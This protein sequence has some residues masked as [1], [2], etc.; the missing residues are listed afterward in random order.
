MPTTAETLTHPDFVPQRRVL[1]AR[2]ALLGRGCRSAGFAGVLGVLITALGLALF[3]SPGFTLGWCA[4]ML[5]LT[6]SNFWFQKRMEAPALSP[7]QADTLEW[8]HALRSAFSGVG[9]GSIATAIHPDGEQSLQVLF[10][11]LVMAIATANVA[12]LAASRKSFLAFLFPALG[13][14]ATHFII[15]PLAALPLTGWGIVLFMLILLAQHDSLH[16]TLLDTLQRQMESDATAQEQQVI[17]DTSA[18]AILFVK[19]DYIL[20]CNRR[21]AEL[22]QVSEWEAAGSPMWIWHADVAT[23]KRHAEAAQAASKENKPY[24]YEAQLRRRNG[25]TFWAELTGRAIDPADLAAGMVWVGADITHRL[26]AAA[27]LRASEERF[28]KLIA[29]SSDIYWES[30]AALCITHVSGAQLKWLQ[31]IMRKAIG[32]PP[33]EAATIEGVSAEQWA[34]H[35]SQCERQETF[36]D[37]AFQLRDDMHERHWFS[38]S[39][40]PMF[41]AEGK[42]L[43]YHGI[44]VDISEQLRNAERYRHLAYHDAL[45]GLPNRRLL[46]DRL[47]QAIILAQR[48]GSLVALMLLDLDDFKIINDTDGHSVGDAVLATVAHRLR[49]IVRGSDTVARLGGDEFVVL[50]P[51]VDSPAACLT[52]ANKLIEAVHEPVYSDQRSYLLGVSI[53]IALFPRD[54]ETGE[55]LLQHADRAMYYAK[56]TGGRRAV[57]TT[58]D[59]YPTAAADTRAP[60]AD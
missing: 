7:N 52:L 42:F 32:Q 29:M 60:L 10:A 1:L 53:G 18:E 41:D 40:T 56:S 6:L 46:A 19:E 21:F 34:H 24:R 13:P 37:F 49:L 27:A 47:E 30:D 8:L 5:P 2:I 16:R 33:W 55:E 14:P 26:A 31:A 9:W 48:H 4:I 20:K 44:C 36:R 51:E 3:K 12:V 59:A 17:F 43:G 57:F 50:L 35:R 22:M 23:W 54:G 15:A 25:E 38:A 11:L 45:T 39:G 58:Q 28:R